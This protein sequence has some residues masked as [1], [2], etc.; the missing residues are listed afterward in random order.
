MSAGKPPNQPSP[1]NSDDNPYP[2]ESDIPFARFREFN[3]S[4]GDTALQ[5]DLVRDVMWQATRTVTTQNMES[6]IQQ[7]ID[8]VSELLSEMYT[9]SERDIVRRNEELARQTCLPNIS[10]W[11]QQLIEGHKQSKLR[12]SEIS[13]ELEIVDTMLRR[14]MRKRK[15]KGIRNSAKTTATAPQPSIPKPPQ[16]IDDATMPSRSALLRGVLQIKGPKALLFTVTV[17]VLALESFENIARHENGPSQLANYAL[18]ASVFLLSF[19]YLHTLRSAYQK[20]N[21]DLHR[22]GTFV[23]KDRRK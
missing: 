3:T 5:N 4:A 14:T 21:L 11:N 19:A 22:T 1:P 16:P 8:A 20:A 17:C 10:K 18:I 13:K 15:S 23:K 7:Q 12:Q 6:T 9:R 2:T